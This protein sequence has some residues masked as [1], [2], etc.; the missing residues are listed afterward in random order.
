MS[1]VF[2]NLVGFSFQGLCNSCGSEAAQSRETSGA[3]A[4][5]VKFERSRDLLLLHHQLEL[6]RLLQR[7]RGRGYCHTIGTRWSATAAAGAPAP[8]AGA[9]APAAAGGNH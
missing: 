4:R 9:P 7:A 8:A 2:N 3:T 5:K 6:D 1:C